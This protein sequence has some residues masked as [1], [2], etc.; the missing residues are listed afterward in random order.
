KPEP[1]PEE[2][3]K[4]MGLFR[5][6]NAIWTTS[7][8]PAEA[9]Y[10]RDLAS[11]LSG[12]AFSTELNDSTRGLL[13]EWVARKSSGQIRSA[14][15]DDIPPATVAIAVSAAMFCS[16]WA[17]SGPEPYFPIKATKDRA[18]AT[19]SNGSKTC[20]FMGRA[21]YWSYQYRREFSAILIPYTLQGTGMV[22]ILPSKEA[23]IEG[24][25]QQ[26]SKEGIGAILADFASAYGIVRMPKYD[27]RCEYERNPFIPDPNGLS[28]GR[29]FARVS[30]RFPLSI[31]KQVAEISVNEEGTEAL[32]VE[33]AIMIGSSGRKPPPPFELTFDRPFVFFI[34]GPDSEVPLFAGIV[35][36]PTDKGKK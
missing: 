4:H 30:M 19:R 15:V 20:P 2:R 31:A 25:L 35:N 14:G 24:L 8:L 26:I 21:D 28:L 5:V 17:D 23:G 29:L 36:D 33:N 6:A 11:Y 1:S 22:V 16:Q 13:D 10:G 27:Y 34:M 9:S 32:A 18:F 3:W 12:E 7:S